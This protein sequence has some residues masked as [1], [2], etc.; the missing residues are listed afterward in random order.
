MMCVCSVLDDLRVSL[1][2]RMET[3]NFICSTDLQGCLSFTYMLTLWVCVCVC[4]CLCVFPADSRRNPPGP[5]G[6][7]PFHPNHSPRTTTSLKNAGLPDR[8]GRVYGTS[9]RHIIPPL[10][11]VFFFHGLSFLFLS[12]F[13]PPPTHTHTP[14]LVTCHW[15]PINDNSKISAGYIRLILRTLMFHIGK[16]WF[17]IMEIHVCIPHTDSV[18]P[19]IK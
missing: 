14:H 2:R 9:T 16:L 5:P 13:P 19:L 12:L 4:V 3:I 18:I 17:S 7:L 11:S 15:S 1:S 8:G 6:F 10:S